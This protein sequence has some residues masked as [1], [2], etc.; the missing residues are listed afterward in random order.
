MNTLKKDFLKVI[1]GHQG[2][3]NSLCKVYYHDFED[4]KDTRQDIILQLWKSFSSFRGESSISTWIYK[5]CLNTILS[6]V[7]KE[8]RRPQEENLNLLHENKVQTIPNSDDD[9]Q[10]LNQIIQSLKDLDK[11]V[12]I[13]YLE[14]YKNHE[15]AQLIGLTP[16]NISTRMNR[17]KKALKVQYKIHHHEFR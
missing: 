16:S 9:L 11:A 2:I 12:V 6:K 17:I 14:G 7:K 1:D 8:K 5:V 3:I 10:L 13:L 4:Q 15:I